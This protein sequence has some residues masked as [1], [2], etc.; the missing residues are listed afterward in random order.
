MPPQLNHQTIQAIGNYS[1]LTLDGLSPA[2]AKTLHYQMLRLRRI[3]E[4]L[5]REYHPANEMRCPIHFCIGQ[6][7]IPAG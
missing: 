5:H 3:E 6:E 2:T 4:A 1:Q 7:S